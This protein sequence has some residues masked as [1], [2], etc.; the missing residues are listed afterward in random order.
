MP[1]VKGFAKNIDKESRS[2]PPAHCI[3]DAA[4]AFMIVPL[5]VVTVKSE[6]SAARLV[7]F[8]FLLVFMLISVPSQ[9]A[10]ALNKRGRRGSV[11]LAEPPP[12]DKE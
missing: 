11:M 9:G 12:K 6:P 8:I 1:G 5:G 10:T 7:H 4:T 3:E 2:N